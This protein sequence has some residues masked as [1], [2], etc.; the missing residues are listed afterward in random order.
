MTSLP[1]PG[2][3]LN[4]E[5]NRFTLARGEKFTSLGSAPAD[6]T[7]KGHC[8]RVWPEVECDLCETQICYRHDLVNQHGGRV[9]KIGSE[10]V[11]KFH[12]A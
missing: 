1:E 6:W 11:V 3:V 4:M 5:Q 10:C 12:E 2:K 8:E 7:Y 9:L